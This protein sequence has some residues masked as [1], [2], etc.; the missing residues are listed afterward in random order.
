M[1]KVYEYF[2]LI[3]FFYSNEH[4][5]IHVHVL[6]GGGETIFEL[7]MDN[8]ELAEVQKRYKKGIEPLC[9]DDE[10][11]AILF[12]EQHYKGI[13]DKWVKF[14]ILKQKVR[15]TKITKKLKRNKK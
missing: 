12:I 9:P 4:E 15:N 6:H 13:I 7:I 10:E 11:D 2:G 3:F 1:P 14:F 5:P 8:G